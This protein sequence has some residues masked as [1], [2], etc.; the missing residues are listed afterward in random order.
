MKEHCMTQ[1]V[2]GKKESA[3]KSKSKQYSHTGPKASGPNYPQWK[4]NG[5][6]SIGKL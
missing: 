6:K 4:L 2:G 3:P 5:G 1:K